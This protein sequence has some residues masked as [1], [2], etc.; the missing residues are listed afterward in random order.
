VSSSR[1]LSRITITVGTL[2]IW[3]AVWGPVEQAMGDGTSQTVAQAS[4]G[5]SEHIETVQG[6][7][8]LAERYSPGS[9]KA[10]T[11][12]LELIGQFEG[13]GAAGFM[14]VFEDCVYYSTWQNS[15]LRHPGVAVLDTSDSRHPKATEY[16]NDSVMV[17]ANESLEIDPAR[18]LLFANRFNSTVFNIYDLS[19]NCRHPVFIGRVTVAGVTFHAG[20]L[21][22]DGRTLYGGSC[23]KSVQQY[24]W[25]PTVP[26]TAI[27][28]IDTSNPSN[29]RAIATWI[30]PD[31][32]EGWFSHAVTLNKDG[33]RAYASFHRV[34][35]EKYS[36]ELA[37]FDV[38]D[39]QA[40]RSDPHFRLVGTLAWDDATGQE[41]ALPLTIKGHPYLIVTDIE[42]AIGGTTPR[43]SNVCDS[44]K[45]G[46][47]FARIID[48]GD[49]R[50]P[51][52]ASTL[53][54]EADAP[55]NCKTVMHDPTVAFGYGSF[56]CSVDDKNNAKLL[57]CGYFEGGLRVFDIRDPNRPSEVAYYKPPAMRT[58]SRPGSEDRDLVSPELTDHTADDVMLPIFR[59]NGE[60]IWF[61]ST[62][63]G[64]QVVRFTG[65]FKTSH[66]DLF[67][68]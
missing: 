33:T 10:Y 46:W 53:M 25:D 45:P 29:L 27:F 19:E 4:C 64:F 51:A 62:D 67:R 54:L 8:T 42:G 43:P 9:A 22:P 63:N 52:T 39:I 50:H 41:F 28:A 44:G 20:Q 49:D 57:A 6:E 56:A 32:Q 1:Q 59:K 38:S 17:N 60:E 37:I 40:R 7:T 12:N 23:C 68:N 34:N 5:P 30:P 2:F 35:G 65:R 14:N 3:L 47:G 58:A 48:I 66:P 16:L 15:M 21:A 24:P 18:K 61:M 31:V 36:S 11:C 13:E 26:P 55:M